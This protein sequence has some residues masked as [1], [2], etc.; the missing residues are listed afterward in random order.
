PVRCAPLHTAPQDRPTLR[1]NKRPDHLAAT[2]QPSPAGSAQLA[3]ARSLRQAPAYGGPTGSAALRG[4]AS[5]RSLRRR[6]VAPAGGPRVPGVPVSVGAFF[7][8]RS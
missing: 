1:A 3:Y 4:I 5:G 8:L 7:A 6:G 2:P